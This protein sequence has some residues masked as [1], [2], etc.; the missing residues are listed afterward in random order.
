MVDLLASRMAEGDF[1]ALFDISLLL[2]DSDLFASWVSRA[3]SLQKNE[4]TAR[5][6]LTAC[7]EAG[8]PTRLREA[9][10]VFEAAGF[11]TEAREARAQLPQV[12]STFLNARLA[13]PAPDIPLLLEAI[14]EAEAEG[15]SEQVAEARAQLPRMVQPDP[16]PLFKEK[17][18]FYAT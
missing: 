16:P 14:F 9:F 1:A 17:Y 15:L 3:R 2:E 11:A 10:R 5:D 6:F 7:L 18:A 4:E 12:A 8:H 13:E